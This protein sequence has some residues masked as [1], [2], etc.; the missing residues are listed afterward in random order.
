MLLN[1]KDFIF[2]ESKPL[3]LPTLSGMGTSSSSWASCICLGCLS[4]GLVHAW[5]LELWL[6]TLKFCLLHMLHVLQNAQ[7]CLCMC[8]APW[9]L[10]CST[11]Y[12]LCSSLGCC[13]ST[14]SVCLLLCIRSKS[15]MLFMSSNTFF[16]TLYT[17]TLCTHTST[18][19]LSISCV[20]FW[21]ASSF[22]DFFYDFF[23]VYTIY[24]LCFEPSLVFFIVIFCV[25]I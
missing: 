24:E 15:F 2:N 4:A 3:L 19:S 23:I 13:L 6:T 12:S 20:F 21:A 7:H 9:S 18:C 5:V 22:Y 17:S 1:V 16:C 10:Q 25:F 14:I 8:A 11:L